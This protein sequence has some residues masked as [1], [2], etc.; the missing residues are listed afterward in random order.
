YQVG[1][2]PGGWGE[3]NDQFRDTV[4]AYWRG[5]EGQLPDLARVV[6]GCREIFEPAGRQPS[7]SVNFVCAHDGFTLN[8][9]VSYNNRHNEANGEDNRDGSN[10]NR[11]WNCGVEGPTDEPAIRNLRMRQKRNLIATLLLSQ[12]VPMVLGGDEL[13]HT[14]SGNNNAYCQD[15]ARSWLQW[16]LDPE[17]EDFLQFVAQMIDL[18]RRHPVFSRRRF[19]QSDAINPE[20]LKEIVWLTPEGGEMTETQWNQH[21]ARCLGVYLAGAAIERRDKRGRPVT[22]NNF[23]L[24]FNAHHEQIPFVLPQFLSDKAWWTVVDT[25]A[26]GNPFEQRRHEAG[27]LYPLQG[28]SLALLRETSYR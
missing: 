7:A 16:E 20:G 2:F 14:Q 13:G 4:R 17:Q 8:D 9:L 28:R 1:G 19:L 12:G 6:T 21:F 27:T 25:S 15:N 24:L 23:M 5:D 18:R 26:A 22:D 10:D 3:W 11:S